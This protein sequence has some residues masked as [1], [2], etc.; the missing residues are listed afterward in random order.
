MEKLSVREKVSYSFGDFASCLIW[1]SISVYFLYFCTNVAGLETATAVTIISVSKILDGL[2]DIAMG[3]VVDRTK[4]RFGKVRP[5]LLYMSAPLAVSTV[6]LFSVPMGFS[7]HA[8]MIWMMVF[9]NLVTTVFYTAMNVP[10]C[11]LH[12]FMT[13]DSEER[14]RLSIMRLLFAFAA[15][16]L[17]NGGMLW[18]VR[19]MGGSV[20]SPRGWTW[21]MIIIGAAAFA[22]AQVCFLNTKERVAS[23]GKTAESASEAAEGAG[24]ANIAKVPLK[25][26]VR[27]IFGNPYM[28]ILLSVT[29]L[30]LLP[31]AI[32]NGA[33][34]YYAQYILGKVEAVGLITS[35]AT[36]AQVLALLLLAPWLLKKF[37]KKHIYLGG[38]ILSFLSFIFCALVPRSLP[39]LLALNFVKGIA[40]GISGPMLTAMI[41]DAIDYSE[42]K[43]GFNSAGFG[44]AMNQ[45]LVKF[46]IG[47]ATALLGVILDAGGFDPNLAAQTAE[48]ERALIGAYTYIPAAFYAAS[49]G[50]ML[51]YRLE[52]IYPKIAAEL[53]ARRDK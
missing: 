25:D 26:S 31:G 28:L 14:G 16:V 33:S 38:L 2:S 50:F 48:A 9:Y 17:I 35:V 10:Y 32:T 40:M 12:C 52:K 18:L 43:F 27:S 21:A 45:A 41:A 1:Q 39:A 7:L 19:L 51:L 24:K 6:L 47:I 37:S 42:W 11:S 3:F 34:A 30:S 29:L 46:G 5:Y 20:T 22:L 15:Q 53:K 44:N 13:D 4:S 36:I 8:K 49:I 23:V